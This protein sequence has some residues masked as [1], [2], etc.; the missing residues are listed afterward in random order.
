MVSKCQEFASSAH[1]GMKEQISYT[2]PEHF[3]YLYLSYYLNLIDLA[4]Y[5][6]NND[7]KYYNTICSDITK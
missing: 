4:Y 6:N 3:L 5:I 7:C 1:D 2:Q